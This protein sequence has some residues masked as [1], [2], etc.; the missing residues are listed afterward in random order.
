[1]LQRACCTVPPPRA[2]TTAPSRSSRRNG[3]REPLIARP[4]APDRVEAS[5]SDTRKMI[6]ASA[7]AGRVRSRSHQAHPSMAGQRDGGQ[8]QVGLGLRADD[9]R[10][11]GVARQADLMAA[12]A[13]GARDDPLNPRVIVDNQNPPRRHVR[14]LTRLSALFRR[15]RLLRT[16]ARSGPARPAHY[17]S[18]LRSQRQLPRSR[19]SG[20]GRVERFFSGR[21]RRGGAALSGARPPVPRRSRRAWSRLVHGAGRSRVAGPRD[22]RPVRRGPK[23]PGPPGPRGGPPGPAPG[24]RGPPKPPPG[25]GGPPKP[26]PGRGPAGLA[27]ASS[28]MMGRPWRMRPES[29]SIEALAPS[30]VAVS[31][32]AKPRG[33]RSRDRARRERCAARSLRL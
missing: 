10:A 14:A 4:R 21:S 1:M 7:Q 24:G 16:S 25:R 2:V 22:Q 29:F 8:D 32:K 33:R 3:L 12:L 31:T 13:E 28:T 27:C 19:S 5:T 17:S 11:G 18:S 6:G 26:P 15:W 30:S 23:P 9:E 20:L